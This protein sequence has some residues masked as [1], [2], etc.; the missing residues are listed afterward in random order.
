MN[1]LRRFVGRI[2]AFVGGGWAEL[3]PGWVLAV[4]AGVLFVEAGMLV[5]L[6]LPGSGVPLT[7]GVL[8]STNVVELPWAVLVSAVAST[9]GAQFA[10]ARARNGEGSALPLFVESAFPK[11]ARVRSR[12]TALV[13]LSAQWCAIAGRMFGGLRTVMP[14]LLATSPLTRAR[15]G[16]LDAVASFVWAAALV[17]VGAVAG[18]YSAGR[19]AYVTVGAVLVATTAI[20]IGVRMNPRSAAE[21]PKPST[22]GAGV[23]AIRPWVRV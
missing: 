2:D 4:A 3:P 17:S 18:Q 7:L 14:R 12:A 6:F 19:V 20:R 13:A 5:G 16:F 8:V 22:R 21:P 1:T 15:Y 10:F 11:L 9:V 23:G